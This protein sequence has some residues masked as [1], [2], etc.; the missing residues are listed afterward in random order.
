MTSLVPGEAARM[1]EAPL[2]RTPGLAVLFTASTT[3]RLANEA[4]RLA[5]VLLVLDRTSSPSLAGAV[6][7]ALTLPSLITGPLLGA[8]LDRTSHRRSAFLANQLLLSAA[9]VALLAAAGHSPS[10]V[11][12][13]LGA[14]AGI[15]SPVL[16]GGFTGLIAPLVPEPLLRRAY[17]AESTS[18][19]VAGVIGPALAAVL[20]AAFSPEAAVAVT[21]GL[22]V[23]ALLAVLRVPM[24][25]P[26][27]APTR[28]LVRTVLGG[29]RH[30]ATTPALRS[31]TVAT[32][33]SFM[34]IGAF[35][36][37][38]PV[39]AV[40]VGSREAASGLLFTAFAVGALAGSTVIAS[41]SPRTGPLRLALL[42]ISG[43][44]V[45]FTLLALS[46]SLWLAIV[47]LFLAGCS[48]G[49]VLASTLAL[50]EE[51]S[52]AWMRTQV[53]TTGASLKFAAY[54]VGSAVAGQL[55]DAEGARAGIWFIASCQLAGVV[56]GS[57]ALGWATLRHRF[58]R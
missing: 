56:A 37:A 48:E 4:A 58:G 5:V 40:E 53:V 50:R 23:I 35:P 57:V 6:V 33:I 38:F 24:P 10:W 55:V 14:A 18:Y 27:G 19:N 36:V 44:T 15:T 8:W 47:L 3:A 7:A 29:F 28:G 11:V 41:R 31:V 51:H 13:L 16:T 46:P 54:A 45:L 32:T 39:L 20:A 26:L 1:P 52:P 43:L 22:S 2:M 9:L 25:P 30:L 34:G 42:G 21:A 49:P 17:G 12:V